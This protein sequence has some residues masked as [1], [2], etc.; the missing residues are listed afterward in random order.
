MFR[1]LIMGGRCLPTRKAIARREVQL[2]SLCCSICDNNE[3]DMI[4]LLKTCEPTNLIWSLITTW[5]SLPPMFPLS[6]KELWEFYKATQT[7]KRQKKVIY[8]CH[9]SYY[10]LVYNL[11]SRNNIHFNNKLMITL[12]KLFQDIKLIK[13]FYFLW[14][15]KTMP[16]IKLYEGNCVRCICV[17]LIVYR[18]ILTR[19][20]S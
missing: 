14:I 2:D 18:L 10:S 5:C 11:E 13:L 9:Y 1:P 4:H 12:L 16:G 7:S 20:G 3:E 17:M 6:T 15:K 19:I 8:I